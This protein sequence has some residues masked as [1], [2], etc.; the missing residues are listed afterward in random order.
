MIPR[1]S[2]T[3]GVCVDL[4]QDPE[5]TLTV[6]VA[7]DAAHAGQMLNWILEPPFSCIGTPQCGYLLVTVDPGAH[8]LHVASAS[9]SLDVPMARL[10]S[11][12]GNHTILVELRN[13]D[14]SLFNGP[15]GKG[16]PVTLNVRMAARCSDAALD[17]GADGTAPPLA[18]DSGG[19]P[20]AAHEAGLDAQAPE[21]SV[22]EA[23]VSDASPAESGARLDAASVDA[24]PD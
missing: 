17:A 8:A 5:K 6:V 14:G 11:P 7:Q 23:S 18:V 21:G 16:A 13:S 10:E 15:A 1:A 3:D 22:S 2:L 4:G 12:E 19:L 9:V 20:D 24:T